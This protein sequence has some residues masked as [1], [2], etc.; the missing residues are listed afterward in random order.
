M[1]TVQVLAAER[2]DADAGE[3]GGAHVVAPCPHDGGCPMDGT[4]SWCHFAQRFQR[5]VLQKTTKA[6]PG[7][8]SLCSC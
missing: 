6:L 4:P 5:T 2:G 7:A 1:L 3:P 8:Q